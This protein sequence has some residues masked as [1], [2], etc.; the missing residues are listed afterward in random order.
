LV[1]WRKRHI[2]ANMVGSV[3]AQVV[4]RE[5]KPEDWTFSGSAH[6]RAQSAFLEL[7]IADGGDARFATGP[8]TL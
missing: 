7:C 4:L 5:M 2:T 8:G 6:E 1:G 3:I